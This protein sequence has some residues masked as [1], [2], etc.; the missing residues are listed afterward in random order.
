MI[1]LDWRGN[2]KGLFLFSAYRPS[3]FST[4]LAWLLSWPLVHSWVKPQIAGSQPSNRSFQACRLSSVLILCAMWSFMLKKRQCRFDIFRSERVNS[5]K[6]WNI[7]NVFFIPASKCN[8]RGNWFQAWFAECCLD[9]SRD[10]LWFFLD[11]LVQSMCLRGSFTRCVKIRHGTTSHW[12]SGLDCGW[13][14]SSYWWWLLMLVLTFATSQ[15]AK[16]WTYLKLFK[17]TH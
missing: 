16:I 14:P 1:L 2:Y 8:L 6:I 9:F 3:S 10:S 12:D 11:Q 5:L 13:L 15:G 4:S 7:G 17:R